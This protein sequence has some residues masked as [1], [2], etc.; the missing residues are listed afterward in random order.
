MK[1]RATVNSFYRVSL[2]D[3]RRL[4]AD[5]GFARDEHK[6]WSHP[7]GRAIGESVVAALTDASLFRYLRLDPPAAPKAGARKAKSRPRRAGK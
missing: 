5:A 3:R 7:D 2:A 1:V 4:L 6:I